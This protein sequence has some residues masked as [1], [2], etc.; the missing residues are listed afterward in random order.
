VAARIEVCPSAAPCGNFI[1]AGGTSP[2]FTATPT[3][4]NGTTYFWR[5]NN[6]FGG[7]PGNYYT[8][9]TS[10][11][12][13]NPPGSL[14]PIG[15]ARTFLANSALPITISW[16][17][18]NAIVPETY[19]E[20]CDNVADTNCLTPIFAGNVAPA[21][22][23]TTGFSFDLGATIPDPATG[24]HWFLPGTYKWRVRNTLA[25]QAPTSTDL[26]RSGL[27]FVTPVA[28]LPTALAP[29]QSGTATAQPVTLSWSTD[30]NVA[31]CEVLLC[32]NP[33]CTAYVLYGSPPQVA[34]YPGI[35]PAVAGALTNDYTLT[36]NLDPAGNAFSLAAGTTFWWQVY[37]SDFAFTPAPIATDSVIGT[38]RT[39]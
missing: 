19:L 3:M 1:A 33:T 2:N 12:A 5:A 38:F 30:V 26:T 27:I 13:V 9:W 32:T 6:L 22:F 18:A 31:N 11:R 36:L 15:A 21:F 35:T 29:N 28:I 7:T 37:A 14:A 24:G 23:G 8:T 4:V 16:T 39:P 10:F 17:T 25:A 20:I 34:I